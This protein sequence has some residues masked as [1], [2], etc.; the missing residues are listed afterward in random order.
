MEQDLVQARSLPTFQKY[1]LQSTSVSCIYLQTEC[2][3]S[4]WAVNLRA[5]SFTTRISHDLFL[6]SFPFWSYVALP[7]RQIILLLHNWDNQCCYRT[8][9]IQLRRLQLA[10]QNVLA[11]VDHAILYVC[12]IYFLLIFFLFTKVEIRMI[13]WSHAVVHRGIQMPGRTFSPSGA[14]P[15]RL[16]W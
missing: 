3:R 7:A 15:C 4:Q 1:N 11:S 10:I 16:S 9:I 2:R 13:T 5:S 6:S 14:D 12:M 8:V